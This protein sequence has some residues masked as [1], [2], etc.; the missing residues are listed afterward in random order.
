ME[1]LLIV[2]YAVLVAAVIHA[3]KNGGFDHEQAGLE[4]TI[5]VPE[6]RAYPGT[7]R[8]TEKEEKR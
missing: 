3:G 4:N 7:G 1:K 5:R 6:Y 2:I 8:G